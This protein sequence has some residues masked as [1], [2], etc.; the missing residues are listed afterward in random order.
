[1]IYKLELEE[2]QPEA[3]EQSAPNAAA[4]LERVVQAEE[5]VARAYT[6]TRTGTNAQKEAATKK[7]NVLRKD[8]ASWKGALADAEKQTTPKTEDAGA[9]TVET[10]PA[11][12]QEIKNSI[13]EGEEI[14]QSGRSVIGRK[15]S[16]EEL[17]SV[18]RAVDKNKAQLGEG[19]GGINEPFPIYTVNEKGLTRT[20]R[21][22][23]NS[24]Q[25]GLFDGIS[26]TPG[27]TLSSGR[28]VSPVQSGT[29]LP[30]APEQ[31]TLPSVQNEPIGKWESSRSKA[32]TPEDA[33]VIAR[34]N[35][36]REAQEH[37]VTI[38]TD[39]DGNVL[40]IN[41]HS[42]GGPSSSQVANQIV[43][44]QILN[45]PGAKKVWL[46]H[47]HP[48]GETQLSPADET[49]SKV[50]KGLVD[51]SGI[52]VMRIIAVAPNQYSTDRYSSLPLPPK[53]PAMH[54]FNVSGR[55][56]SQN[57]EGMIK[58]NNEATIRD[59]GEKHLKD[60]GII[61]TSV[62]AE[63]VALINIKD[64]EQLRPNHI[65]LLRE[66][67]TRNAT[68]LIVYGG[69]KTLSSL[70]K[71]NIVN[72]AANASLDIMTVIDN[73]G[74]H[75][76]EMGRQLADARE[77]LAHGSDRPFYMRSSVKPWPSDFPKSFSHTT[78]GKVTQ[79][80]DHEAAKAGDFDAAR[81]LVAD[82]VKPERI[83]DLADRFPDAIIVPVV[84]Q[85]TKGIN[86]IPKALAELYQACG[87]RMDDQMYQIGKAKRSGLDAA[88]RLLAR[89]EFSGDVAK[90]EKYILVDDVLTQ[91]G[92]IHELR[93][94]IVN[95]G[96]EVVGVISLAFSAG[97]NI[98]AIKTETV[99]DLS[100]RFGREKLER[101]LDEYNI[102]GTIE[103][104]TESEGR[105]I[106]RFKSLDTL[107]NRLTEASDALRQENDSGEKSQRSLREALTDLQFNIPGSP[108]TAGLSESATARTPTRGVSVGSVT[109]VVEKVKSFLKNPPKINVV[110]NTSE[111]PI[112]I[113]DH[114]SEQGLLDDNM[115]SDVAG[116]TWEGEIWIVANNNATTQD[117][118]KNLTHELVHSGL[119][120]FLKSQYG[121]IK[122]R[123][124]RLEYKS[125]MDAIYKAH[126]KE[127]DRIAKT[128]HTHL[129]TSTVTGQR[130]AAEEWLASQAYDAQ[131]KWY[132][133]MVALFRDAM[134]A[135]GLDVQMSD[136][137]VRVVLQ[138]AFKPFGARTIDLENKNSI[139]YSRSATSKPGTANKPPETTPKAVGGN[140]AL[141][142]SQVNI[143]S[144]PASLTLKRSD[145]IESA[146]Q[147]VE[148]KG[149]YLKIDNGEYAVSR[150]ALNKM[151]AEHGEGGFSKPYQ[152][153]R[154]IAIQVLPEL[155]AAA[156][157]I[158]R[159][160]DGRAPRVKVIH[161][162]YAPLEYQGKLYSVRILA[163]EFTDEAKGQDKNLKDKLHSLRID[164]IIIGEYTGTLAPG[165]SS[166]GL[167]NTGIAPARAKSDA[168]AASPTADRKVKLRQL[169]REVKPEVS[170]NPSAPQGRGP[171]YSVI[172]KILDNPE[173]YKKA[174]PTD[175]TPTTPAGIKNMY[176]HEVI[177]Q[178]KTQPVASK[179]AASGPKAD[180]LHGA[181][182]GLIRDLLHSILSVKSGNV[183]QY[184]LSKNTPT[185]PAPGGKS[186]SRFFSVPLN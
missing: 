141:L 111:L 125:L 58:L 173:G 134:R 32:R 120:T 159:P 121:N 115:D 61:L 29:I 68:R 19:E 174:E 166:G 51:D 171:Q 180:S 20:T 138:D 49:V 126:Q 70:E 25:G 109:S 69:D 99:N 129:D 75:Y 123:S 147:A 85:E 54:V 146:L 165:V 14:L 172:Q 162:L 28:G 15:M 132:D 181:K 52:A 23:Q 160:D 163:K 39:A 43:A 78:V 161:E 151:T 143:V 152:R 135:I 154:I 106:L 77:D 66:A 178:Q 48:S 76:Y 4:L 186:Y 12:R 74:D 119:G 153:E 179:S 9:V 87:L 67:E 182:V 50:I 17:A 107:R 47:N 33:A 156:K 7:Y 40:S 136:A 24:N 176:V 116:V 92:T 167:E 98:I 89:K 59:F 157:D 13:A 31:G 113:L 86:R 148:D 82:V 184:P 144:A 65:D 64:F 142:D 37:L 177:L 150:S 60:G 16:P 26:D 53:Q 108:I 80:P 79:H 124:I 18:Q 110:Q 183:R 30:Y 5:E 122:L 168:N 149:G 21:K 114:M 10:D 94:H 73:A 22:A 105:A 175:E 1:T 96:G 91:G 164:D 185:H 8:L 84:E 127:V 42:V 11:K 140:D 103:A 27:D 2:V 35:L 145:A 71:D 90:G 41:Q 104:L 97:S 81:R 139:A 118:I 158:P 36:G 170:P 133:R 131:P 88:Q 93:H 34:D 56:F 112:G 95:N 72:F 62:Q 100:G 102:S 137:E 169:I 101:I 3:Q 57:P 128:T 83:A 46:V 155:V 117:V 63:P 130:Q 6:K 45:T 38:V 44:G 55:K